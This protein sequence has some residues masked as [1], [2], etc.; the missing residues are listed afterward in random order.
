M[1]FEVTEAEVARMVLD[2]MFPDTEKAVAAIVFLG[3][4]LVTPRAREITT[5]ENKITMIEEMC[6]MMKRAVKEL[7]NSAG[8]M[9]GQSPEE[10]PANTN[11]PH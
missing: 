11:K 6:D 7:D 8:Q 4:Y 2:I 5:M 1:K 9:S 10:K 3:W